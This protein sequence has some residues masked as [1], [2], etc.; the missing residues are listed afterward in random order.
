MLFQHDNDDEDIAGGWSGRT[1]QIWH[2]SGIDLM[3]PVSSYFCLY[4]V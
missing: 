3:G 4:G 1:L 2:K